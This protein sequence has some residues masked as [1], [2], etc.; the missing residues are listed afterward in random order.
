LTW[1]N[2]DTAN[3][4]AQLS[5]A[6]G[7]LAN[8][9]D[10]VPILANKVYVSRFD[11]NTDSGQQP[12]DSGSDI[13]IIDPGV[14]IITGRIDVVAAMP[15][16]ASFVVHPDRARMVG[17]RVY[18][19]LPYYDLAYNAGPSYVASIDSQTDQIVDLTLLE[20]LSGCSGLDVAPDE[21]S[22]AVVCSGGWHGINTANNSTSG[23]IGLQLQPKLTEIWRVPAKN[24][25]NR[26]FGFEVAYIDMTHVV[27]LQLGD[28]GPP[29]TND[30]VFLIDTAT[31]SSKIL[32]KSA[33]VPITLSVGPCNSSF[34]L[35]YIADAQRSTI[36]RLS[37]NG[38][39]NYTM[40]DYTWADPT[41]LPPRLL[42]FF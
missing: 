37:Y 36:H 31:G 23:I 25:G 10:Y 7:F 42:G 8:P 30:A 29:M 18:A 3:V 38:G 2:I 41:G 11:P 9:H 28:L 32:L 6:T 39:Q 1:V 15:K 13:L 17:N 35:C 20:G 33:N 16:F 27:T 26:A 12:F 19:V 24:V 21:T 22:L 4:R 14:P 34:N 5:V 40:S